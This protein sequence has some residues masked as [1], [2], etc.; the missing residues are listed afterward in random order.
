M[1]LEVTIAQRVTAARGARR[2]GRGR[3]GNLLRASARPGQPPP[4]VQAPD[5]GCGQPGRAGAL[6]APHARAGLERGPDHV[7]IDVD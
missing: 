3:A 5:P 7:K 4:R 2:S 1:H 6:P